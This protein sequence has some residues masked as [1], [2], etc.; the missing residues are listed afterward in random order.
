MAEA[1]RGVAWSGSAA[2]KS[3]IISTIWLRGVFYGRM[4]GVK[5]N[6][7]VGGEGRA[8]AVSRQQPLQQ[9]LKELTC[10]SRP[11]SDRIRPGADLEPTRGLPGAD[12]EPT[13]S[14]YHG[15]TCW[16]RQDPTRSLSR[17]D[18][19]PTGFVQESTRRRLGSDQESTGSRPEADLE[20][21]WSHAVLG[22][23]GTAAE[24]GRMGH[25]R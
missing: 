3:P 22:V 9:S 6:R 10:W 5:L 19:V 2:I 17:A 21:T 14:L 16:S 23:Y 24:V 25:E 4:E 8:E 13:R 20:P 18:L 7:V 11:G 12:L 15:L 1:R